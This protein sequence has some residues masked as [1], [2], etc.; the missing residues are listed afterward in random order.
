[1][2]TP[3]LI[4]SV[5][6]SGEFSETTRQDA[7]LHVMVT[8]QSNPELAAEALRIQGRGYLEAG[9]VGEDGLEQ[10][11]PLRGALIPELDKSRGPNTDYYLAINPD[12]SKTTDV[13]TMRKVNLPAGG[14]FDDLPTGTL[15]RKTLTAEGAA[16]VDSIE[17][18]DLHLKE[19][20]GLAG[21][22]LGVYETIRHTI[23]E[24]QGKGE[25]WFFSIVSTTFATMQRRFGQRNFTVIGEQVTLEDDHVTNGISLVP[26]LVR[27]D[28]FI[29]NV[30]ADYRDAE[31]QEDQLAKRELRRSFLF[32]T[33]GLDTQTMSPEAFAARDELLNTPPARR[34]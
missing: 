30:L 31:V 19:I 14:T 2:A 24:A 7:Y 4:E 28:V 27:P 1:M 33:D 26:A 8:E 34:V 32:L 20:G 16:I 29:D 22:P 6:P 11:G 25:V 3:Y 12:L 15:A 21:H 9:F 23:Q 10:S 17:N 5:Q 18:P 13:A